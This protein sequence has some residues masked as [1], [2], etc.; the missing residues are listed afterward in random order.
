MARFHVE[1][2]RRPDIGAFTN[3]QVNAFDPLGAAAHIYFSPAEDTSR[4]MSG[5]GITD[6]QIGKYSARYRGLGPEQE[7]G[8]GDSIGHS[9]VPILFDPGGAST[10]IYF[11]RTEETIRQLTET[12]VTNELGKVYHAKC[13]ESIQASMNTTI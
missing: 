3:C 5:I 13:H 1:L 12:G 11:T 10:R 4:R 2:L 7:Q 6:L 9:S 8:A